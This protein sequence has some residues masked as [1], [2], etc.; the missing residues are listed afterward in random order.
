MTYSLLKNNDIKS[1][2]SSM[3]NLTITTYDVNDKTD[4]FEI[5]ESY[6]K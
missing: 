2:H 1:C 4:K 6:T 5:I 3:S